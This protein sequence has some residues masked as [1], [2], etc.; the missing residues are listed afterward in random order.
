VIRD[1]TLG[2]IAAIPAVE[3]EVI[4]RDA[5]HMDF[6]GRGDGPIPTTVRE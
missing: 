6:A 3:P 5:N 2:L 4:I 1:V